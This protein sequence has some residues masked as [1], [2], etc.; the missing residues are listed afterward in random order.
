MSGPGCTHYPWVSAA[1]AARLPAGVSVLDT[2]DAVARQ[3][4][5][6]LAAANRLGGGQGHLKVATSGA[7]GT[8][9]ATVDRLW[10]QHLHVEHWEP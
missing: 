5:R 10:G 9:S 3:L 8:V 4:E 6:L 2:G 1:I 7:P